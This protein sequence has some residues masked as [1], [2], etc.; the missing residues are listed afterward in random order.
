MYGKPDTDKRK[1]DMSSA[2]QRQ[3]INL[4]PFDAGLIAVLLYGVSKP[5]RF[6]KETKEE[7]PWFPNFAANCS[8]KCSRSK[9]LQR[10]RESYDSKPDPK[11]K[12][13]H[14]VRNPAQNRSLAYDFGYDC[15]KR[16]RNSKF[17]TNDL[18][19]LKLAYRFS[20]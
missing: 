5:Y 12:T 19:D 18:T 9:P 14:S 11:I 3:Y 1:A 15:N 8:M 17:S 10:E 4:E 6:L 16:L 7:T 20:M 13:Y 2:Y